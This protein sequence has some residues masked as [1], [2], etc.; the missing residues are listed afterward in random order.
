MPSQ[1]GLITDARTAWDWVAERA[2]KNGKAEDNIVVVGHSL[3]TGVTSALAGQL[4]DEGELRMES[5]EL[6]TRHLPARADTHRA[7][8]VYLGAAR[9]VSYEPLVGADS[10]Y[11]LFGVIPL[12]SPIRAIPPVAGK[13]VGGSRRADSRILQEP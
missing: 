4:A 11:W 9:F 7:L 12:L 3:G 10:R 8:H 5:G 13:L 6:T 2:G 1:A